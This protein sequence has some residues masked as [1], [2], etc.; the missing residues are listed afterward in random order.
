MSPRLVLFGLLVSANAVA[1]PSVTATATGTA[2]NLDLDGEGTFGTHIAKVATVTVSTTNATGCDLVIGS[3]ALEKIGGLSVSYQV[4]TVAFGGAAPLAGDFSVPSGADYTF[5]TSVS[6]TVQR[7]V[8]VL[9]TTR[10]LQD[11]GTYVE[12]L[13]FSVADH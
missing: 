2:S 11:P 7:D 6:G 3:G 10:S 9:Y 5:A 1:A 8:W 13:L 4:T 12:T